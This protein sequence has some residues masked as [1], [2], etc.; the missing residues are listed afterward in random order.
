[1]RRYASSPI[2][3]EARA[4][5]S[6]AVADDEWVFVSGT[7][8]MD[9]ASG[10]FPE[11]A[12]EQ[13]RHALGNVA[14]SLGQ[15]GARLGDVVRVVTYAADREAL[16]AAAPVFAEFFKDIRPVSTMVLGEQVDPRVKLQVEVTAR[17][18]QRA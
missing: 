3:E 12:A 5:Y 18:P 15:V 17:R 13:A 7:A 10:E 16:E 11:D 1:M 9:G 4:G 8:G 14:W 2:P 6:R